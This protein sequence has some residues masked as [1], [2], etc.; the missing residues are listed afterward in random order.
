MRKFVTCLLMVLIICSVVPQTENTLAE[1]DCNWT[2]MAGTN[3]EL[4]SLLI[5][6]LPLL[7]MD[8]K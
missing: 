8:L 3:K 5:I 1:N 6:V 4:V 2:M 7:K